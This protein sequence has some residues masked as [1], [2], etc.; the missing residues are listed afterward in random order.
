LESIL[1]ASA[2]I[3]CSL[4][5]AL[6]ASAGPPAHAG[7]LSAGQWSPAGC[8]TPPQAPALN[9]KDADAFNLSIVAVNAYRGKVR[10]FLDCLRTDANADIQ[11]VAQSANAIQQAIK[12][13]NDKI[14]ADVDAADGKFK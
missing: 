1:S 8:G 5:L 11:S 9:L 6:A 2:L 4:V 3:P 7:T 13:V 14:Q 10:E 12:D